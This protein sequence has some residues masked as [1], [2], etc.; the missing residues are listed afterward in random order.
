MYQFTQLDENPKQQI[1]MLLDN[2]E[3]VTFY[4]EY[5][6]NQMGW[7]FGFAYGDIVY[8]NIRLV[9]HYNMLRYYEYLPFGLRCDTLDNFEP[10]DIDD[11]VSG[12]A[13]VY[14][15]TQSDVK[16]IEGAYYAKTSA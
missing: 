6:A 14:L 2:G 3:E 16:A 5:K 7:F 11:F 12:Y 4:F 9:T 1:K 10:M 15:L 8:Q 13:T